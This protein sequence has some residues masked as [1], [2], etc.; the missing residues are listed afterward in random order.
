M[1][2]LAESGPFWVKVSRRAEETQQSSL[3]LAVFARE[4][5]S[6]KC[7]SDEWSRNRSSL[8]A[9]LVRLAPQWGPLDWHLNS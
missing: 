8:V 2:D 1:L 4:R 3:L 5:C 7:F 6:E 9:V